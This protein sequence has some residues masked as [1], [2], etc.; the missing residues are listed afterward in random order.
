MRYLHL[1]RKDGDRILSTGGITVAYQYDSASKTLAFTT[2]R[3]SLA[4]N[5]NKRYGRA[6]A[7]GR[8]IARKGDYKRTTILPDNVGPIDFL[9]NNLNPAK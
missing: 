9:I 1:R 8:F 7:S 3:C 2:A 4:D 5:Y 6:K